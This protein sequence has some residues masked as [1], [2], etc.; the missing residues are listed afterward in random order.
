ML[1]S[2]SWGIEII[3]TFNPTNS[4]ICQPWNQDF[5]AEPQDIFQMHSNFLKV[6]KTSRHIQN[7]CKANPSTELHVHQTEEHRRIV[8]EEVESMQN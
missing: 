8:R 4:S 5:L 3:A 2:E 6:V 1:H 7:A